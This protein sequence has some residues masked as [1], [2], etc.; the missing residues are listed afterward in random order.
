MTHRP[1]PG[2]I[3]KCIWN[4]GRKGNCQQIK[5][6]RIEKLLMLRDGPP[7]SYTTLLSIFSV[8]GITMLRRGS[9]VR[10]FIRD[11]ITL[12]PVPMYSALIPCLLYTSPSPRDGLLSRMP[13]SA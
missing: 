9:I 5:Q 10:D 4:A 13:S 11:I 2:V 12:E 8:L 7:I 6:S 1:I 3:D